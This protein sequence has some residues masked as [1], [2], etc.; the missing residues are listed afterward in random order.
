MHQHLQ[1]IGP[2]V[3]KDIGMV[4]MGCADSGDDASQGCVGA[5]ANVQWVRGQQARI[6]T[7]HAGLTAE[8]QAV[9]RRTGLLQRGPISMAWKC[10]FIES[11]KPH[12]PQPVGLLMAPNINKDSR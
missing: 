4:G 12:E 9:S 3:G 5:R 2:L 6:D 8:T 7:D 11:K 1:A 10:L